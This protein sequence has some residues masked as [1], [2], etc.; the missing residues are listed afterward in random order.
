MSFFRVSNP[1]ASP[2]VLADLGITIAASAT[3][4]V[5]SNQFS[6]NDL[7]LSADLEAA[8]IAGDLTVEIDYGTGF[9]GVAAVDYTNRDAMASFLNI[10]EITNDNNNEKLVDGSDVDALHMHDGRYYT[11]TEIGASTGA[12]L[13]GFDDTGL[14]YITASDVQ[15]AISDLDAAIGAI[16]LDA[17]YDNDADG[18]MHI[19]G[20]AKP[21]KL[22]SNG[23]N[24]VLI[25]REVG[26]DIQQ[27][28]K[29]VFGSDEIQIGALPVGSLAAV[30]TR[31]LGDLYIDG[32]LTVVGTVTDTTVN[33]LNITNASIRLRDG[34]TAVPQ[35][36]ASIIVERGTSGTDASLLWATAS[37]RWKA[38]LEGSEQTIALLEANENVTGVW[39]FSGSVSTDPNMYL[40]DKA[41][42]PTTQLGAAGEI[43]V[44]SISNMLAIYDKTNSRN[45]FLGVAR[46]YMTF[47]GRDSANNSNEYLRVGLFTSNQAGIRLMRNATLTGISAQTNGAETWNVRVRKNGVVTDL[48]TLVLSAVSGAQDEYNVDFDAG[49]SVEVYLDGTQIDRP[50]VTLEFRE[51]F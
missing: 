5:L 8:I 11:E 23:T 12:G 28:L 26:S 25:E 34:A 1:V 29:T 51:R 43:P 35:A 46:Q 9:A 21:L 14:N 17:V 38:G 20:V 39:K 49:D 2:F 40:A 32:S 7:Y 10:Y 42:A 37:N 13:V 4:V 44:A 33:E 15:D 36:N 47:S 30:M 16:D 31:V 41:A 50:L 6:V 18:I 19:D 22:R 45:R 48:A 27:V 24:D 3:N